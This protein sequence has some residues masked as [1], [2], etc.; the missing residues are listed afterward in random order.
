[1]TLLDLHLDR[2][3]AQPARCSSLISTQLAFI[4]PLSDQASHYQLTSI[5]ASK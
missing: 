1:M 2:M 4:F 3:G 5:V